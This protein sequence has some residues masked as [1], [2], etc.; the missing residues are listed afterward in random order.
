MIINLFTELTAQSGYTPQTAGT[1]AKVSGPGPSAPGTYNGTIDFT[2]T[3]TGNT[4]YTYTVT[5]DTCTEVATV[6]VQWT[7]SGVRA[8]DECGTI[9]TAILGGVPSSE[10]ILDERF[11]GLCPALA[12]STPSDDPPSSW[13]S[14]TFDDLWY[15]VNAPTYKGAYTMNVQIDGTPYGVDGVYSPVVALYTSCDVADLITAS[16]PLPSGQSSTCITSLL[17]TGTPAFIYIR[18]GRSQA[19]IGGY[20]FDLIITTYE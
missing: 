9:Y 8:N 15:R 1:W 3:T 10:S 6:T 7:L 4:I 17:G 13:G 19:S 12:P 2:G 5:Q 20:R 11:D 18:V 14:A 16:T